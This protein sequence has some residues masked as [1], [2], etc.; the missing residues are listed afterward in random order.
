MR[1]WTFV[2][3]DRRREAHELGAGPAAARTSST[4]TGRVPREAIDARLAVLAERPLQAEQAGPEARRDDSPGLLSHMHQAIARD[5]VRLHV[6]DLQA[7]AT[8]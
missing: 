5:A 3:R 1:V 2:G 6:C 8:Q 4:S 7:F